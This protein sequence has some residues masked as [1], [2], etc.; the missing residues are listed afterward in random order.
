MVVYHTEGSSATLF[1]DNVARYGGG[2]VSCGSMS[3]EGSVCTSI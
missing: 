2:A 1:S 3:F